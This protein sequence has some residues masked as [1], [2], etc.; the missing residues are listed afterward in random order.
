MDLRW[1][2]RGSGASLE[3]AARLLSAYDREALGADEPPRSAAAVDAWLDP[4]GARRRFVLL[5]YEG[6]EVVGVASLQLRRGGGTDHVG[7]MRELYV[8]PEA[9]RRRVGR[10]LTD[11]LRTVTFADGRAMLSFRHLVTN[12]SG[13]RFADHLGARCNMTVDQQRLA[14]AGLRRPHLYHWIAR[15]TERARD[16]EIITWDDRCPPEHLERF[17]RAHEVMNDAPR[18]ESTGDWTVS[19]EQIRAE[20]AMNAHTETAQWVVVARHRASGDFAGYTEMSFDPRE[21][22]L[23]RQGDTAVAAVHRNRGIGRWIKAHNL[24]RLMVDRPQVRVV[25]TANAGGND[26]MLR[27][28]AELGFSR[29]AEWQEREL[30]FSNDRA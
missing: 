14:I 11:E 2:Q 17:A 27:I 10:V 8:V 20:E 9:R 25:E 6:D 15:A 29:V 13:R 3:D 4:P 26:A 1:V 24:A 18:P 22:W 5:A 12:E 19:T 7:W 16:Y 21:Q 28:N 30:W 23:A